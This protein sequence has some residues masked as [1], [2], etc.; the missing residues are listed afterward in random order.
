[1]DTT[2]IPSLFVQSLI[3]PNTKD[4]VDEELSKKKKR[5][6]G[7]R[8]VLDT[9]LTPA[10]LYIYLKARFGP[11]N[12][13]IMIVR[14]S[15]SD[16]F[17]QWHYTLKSGPSYFE[18]LGLNTRT[19]LLISEYPNLSNENWVELVTEIKKDF[20][21]FGPKLKEVRKGI[22]SWRL[23]YNPYHRL[24]GI[25]KRYAE[26]LSEIIKDSFELPNDP[27]AFP[28]I[29]SSDQDGH[30]EDV[31]EFTTRIQAVTNRYLRAQEISTSLRLICPVWG[32][33]FINFLIFILS[34][35]EIKNDQRLYQDFIRKDIDVKIKLL[36]INCNGFQKTIDTKHKKYKEFHSLM[37]ERNDLLHGNI[38]PKKLSYETVYFDD[39]IPLFTE[40]QGLARNS[41]GVS[42]VGIEPDETLKRID[43]VN[44]FIDFI[45]SHLEQ[46]YKE[47]L[48]LIL[49]KRDLGWRDET[50]RLGVLFSDFIAEGYAR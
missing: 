25:V 11:P 18:I 17:I 37:N 36:H 21:R 13:L 46:P 40:P 48:S 47:Q 29:Y 14:G 23:F 34:R 22:E 41:L 3:A 39:T 28:V 44:S 32:E 20:K 19:E 31:S 1:M 6:K 30:K 12:G 7:S 49:D 10:D 9:S 35:E 26:E 27:P 2:F 16:N 8:W 38:D 43:I 50:K 42:L 24:K 4:L 5:G 45:L 33:A 15:H